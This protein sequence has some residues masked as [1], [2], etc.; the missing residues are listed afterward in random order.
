M[1]APTQTV[2]QII[3]DALVLLNVKASGETLTD[4]EAQDGMVSLNGLIDSWS[5]ENL[6]QPNEIQITH[7][8]T[9]GDETYTIGASGDINTAWPTKL[10][11]A[12][13]RDSNLDYEMSVITPREYD[14]IVQ[15]GLQ[16][17]YPRW[18]MYDKTYPLGTLYLY[19]TPNS[20]LSLRLRVNSEIAQYSSL[21]ATVNLPPGFIRAIKYNLALEMAPAYKE[22]SQFIQKVAVESKKWIKTANVGKVPPL[23]IPS[24]YVGNRNRWDYRTGGV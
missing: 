2:K 24:A 21:T 8:L 12:H 5:N 19:P 16:T 1:A 10:L 14:N 4:A 9:A 11:S 20:A 3:T 18:I 13:V 22:P 6:M 15:K 23:R 7:T 17:D